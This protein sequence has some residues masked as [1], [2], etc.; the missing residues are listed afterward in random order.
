M[1]IKEQTSPILLTISIIMLYMKLFNLVH[2]SRR[3]T[4]AT[5]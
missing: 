3:R 5:Q 2:I 1:G 4:D